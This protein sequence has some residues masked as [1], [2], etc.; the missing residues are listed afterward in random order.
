[1][2]ADALVGLI[3]DFASR[4]I[5]PNPYANSDD[6]P[7]DKAGLDFIKQVDFD[8]AQPIINHISFPVQIYWRDK[9]EQR[10]FRG[11]TLREIRKLGDHYM[12]RAICDRTEEEQILNGANIFELY[13]GEYGKKYQQDPKFT[14]IWERGLY[15]LHRKYVGSFVPDR[16]SMK[17]EGRSIEQFI[18]QFRIFENNNYL[19]LRLRLNVLLFLARLDGRLCDDERRIIYNYIV[20]Q[21]NGTAQDEM[22]LYSY[23]NHSFITATEFVKSAQKLELQGIPALQETLVQAHHLIEADNTISMEEQQFFDQI[24]TQL[25]GILR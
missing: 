23:V 12:Y 25:A 7:L 8:R 10:H 22:A 6:T 5:P 21:T 1:M 4:H 3:K 17:D 24:N 14:D 19:E 15:E 11:I 16:E 20:D 13:A 18:E 2:V 9:D